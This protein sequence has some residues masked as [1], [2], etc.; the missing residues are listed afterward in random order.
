MD[1]IG[2]EGIFG[3]GLGVVLNMEVFKVGLDFE[4]IIGVV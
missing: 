4:F 1:Y 2:N 3:I